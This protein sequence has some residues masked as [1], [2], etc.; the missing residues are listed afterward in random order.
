MEEGLLT[1]AI[2]E[3][4]AEASCNFKMSPLVSPLSRGEQWG[5][6]REAMRAACGPQAVLCSIPFI[7]APKSWMSS[8][9]D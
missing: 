3:R 5:P 2:A 7:H 6:L 8:R 4:P 9:L 1:L